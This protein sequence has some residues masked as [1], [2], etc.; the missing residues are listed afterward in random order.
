MFCL[1]GACYVH[2]VRKWRRA[3][4]LMVN[5]RALG[6]RDFCCLFIFQM[7]EKLYVVSL[8]TRLVIMGLK[9]SFCYIVVVLSW[10][11]TGHCFHY[12]SVRKDQPQQWTDEQNNSRKNWHCL[13]PTCWNILQQNCE[14]MRE[15]WRMNKGHLVH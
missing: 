3:I 13:R 4:F 8:G 6:G 7:F 11:R 5:F 15:F 10:Y 14:N 2:E 12:Y 9:M 1:L